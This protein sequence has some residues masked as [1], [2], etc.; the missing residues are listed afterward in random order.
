MTNINIAAKAALEFYIDHGVDISI[1]DEA[2]DRMM[3]NEKVEILEDIPQHS[4]IPTFQD[5]KTPI[6]NKGE[7]HSQAITLAQSANTLDE[8]RE[9]IAAFDDIA[10]KKTAT[11]MVF[12]DGN[13]NADIM[14][15]GD[16]PA[17]DEDRAGKAFMGQSGQLLDK[18][19]ACIDLSRTED[20]PQQSAYL[21]N[22]LNW[23][24]PGNRSPTNAEISLST[25]FVE[26]HIQLA[27]PK[28]IILCGGVAAKTLLG[29]GDSISKLR[30]KWH[31]YT[32]QTAAL[33]DGVTPIPTIVTYHPSYLLQNP[34]QKKAVWMDMLEV[35]KK[36]DA[37][38]S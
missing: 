8:L 30:K 1:A 34:A 37:Q 11:N 16:I 21:T 35:K 13:P 9:V 4:N 29:S 7:A 14:L 18:I 15:I 25:P 38:K 5:S 19:L 17:A 32:P 20:A 31:D 12:A 33:A 24:P 22:V 3:K 26:R 2:V 6:T 23:R 28:L 27:A 36:H 10:I